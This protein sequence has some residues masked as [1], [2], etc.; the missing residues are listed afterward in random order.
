MPPIQEN[1]A[2]KTEARGRVRPDA[3]R[4][5]LKELE[6]HFGTDLKDG[7]SPKMAEKR[8]GDREDESLFAVS[9]PK[10][11]PCVKT[12]LAEPVMWLL[13]AV[14]V[15]ALF[16]NRVEIGLFSILL[17]VA[18]AVTCIILKYRTLRHHAELQAYDVPLARVRR[19]RRLMRVRGDRLVPGDV[20]LLRRG[21]II[22]CDARLITSKGLTVAEETL[23][24]D[25]QRRETVL[26]EKDAKATPETSPHS[27]SPAN[28]VYAGGVVR[29]GQA[30]ALVVAVASRTHL[31]GRVGKMGETHPF[32][33]PA[34]IE[35]LRKG[36]STLNLILAVAAVPL[37]ALGILTGGGR[38]EFLDIFMSA[39]SLSVLTLT[40]HILLYGL[41]H[42]TCA[43][44]MA[45]RDADT[46]NAAE[47]RTPETMENLCRMDHLI[48]MGTAALHDGENHP[49]Y[50]STCGRLCRVDEVEPDVSMRFFA[51]KL[52]LLALGQED[53]LRSGAY[54]AFPSLDTVSDHISEWAAPDME[55]ALLRLDRL[56]AKGDAVV[57]TMRN[58]PPVTLHLTDDP[59]VCE[60]CDTCRDD[61]GTIPMDDE[62]LNIHLTEWRKAYRKGERVWFLVSEDDWGRC[63][64]GFIGLAVG[65]CLKT[66]GSIR[67]LEEGGL[68]VVSFLRDALPEDRRAL[69]DAGL[70]EEAPSVEL[71]EGMN[72]A[73]LSAAVDSGVRSF[74]GCTTNDVLNYIDEL[75]SKGSCVG[76]LS[77]ERVDLPLLEAA[78]VAFTCTPHT[79]KEVLEGGQPC[80]MGARG[81]ETDGDPDSATAS[82]LCRRAAHVM[83]R[84]CGTHGGGICGVRRA[85][86]ASGQL[87]R[88]LNMGLRF[89]FLSQILR[90]LLTATLMITGTA[91]LPAPVLLLSGLVVDALALFCYTLCDLPDSTRREPSPVRALSEPWRRFKAEMILT[92]VSVMVP[93]AVSLVTRLVASSAM[94]DMA[95]YAAL[96]LLGTQILL[97]ATG[98]RP[99][100]RRRGFFTL[101]LMVCVY[102][103][104]LSVALASGLHV[105]Y[106]LLLP[107]L[108]PLL[109][110]V[111]YGICRF[112][113][114]IE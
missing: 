10:V 69:T 14:C 8:L 62:L 3:C 38:Y 72:A 16:F 45:A 29:K 101:V 83:V 89:V 34:Y 98:H 26:L 33:P 71:T 39:L 11:G 78:D 43:A 51:E 105:I 31:G 114:K 70:T 23:Y 104:L 106:S 103:G 84:R 73:E 6:A 110:L 35:K 9:A 36:M 88:G 17:L 86:L 63:L 74:I 112:T 13:L 58:A 41:Y 49:L 1:Q 99:R 68:R 55:A 100:R 5:T 76:V 27:H 77:V 57:M 66:K 37:T 7:L 20:I 32:A 96:S 93:L 94:G 109:W 79:L 19:N 40:E 82:D 108:Q 102:V 87:L 92:A 64:E 50:V 61:E 2:P 21:D 30:R 46:V 18:N 25:D 15:V 4:S 107:L 53:R 28:M 80:V 22:P 54:A 56:E 75:H 95:Y 90:L 91:C 67:G 85:K 48:L 97:F 59:A 44:Q 81:G 47:L 12:V 65:F 113:K 60:T 42:Y 111:G 24:G 52:H